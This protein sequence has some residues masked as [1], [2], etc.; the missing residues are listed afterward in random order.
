MTPQEPSDSIHTATNASTTEG[1]PVAPA[2]GPALD[3]VAAPVEP[4]LV[5]GRTAAICGAAM[6][7]AAGAGFVAKGLTAVIV[8][9]TNVSFYGRFSFA[10]VSPAEAITVTVDANAN[11]HAIDARRAHGAATAPPFRPRATTLASG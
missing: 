6:L 5:D 11:R 3:V 8:F 1:L 2:M 10:A 7:V 9:V 4:A